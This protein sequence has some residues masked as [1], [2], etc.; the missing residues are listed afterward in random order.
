MAWNVAGN[1]GKQYVSTARITN[2]QT[3]AEWVEFHGVNRSAMGNQ[4][5]Y[6]AMSAAELKAIQNTGYLRGGNPGDTYFTNNRYTS[7]SAAQRS[8]S[9]EHRPEHMVEFRIINNPNIVGGPTGTTVTPKYGQPGGGIEFYS[10]N[11]VQVEI[12]NMWVLR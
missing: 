4:V 1:A 6:R 5:Y 11:A 10:T 8:L 3:R 12:T 2:P 9:L 7:A